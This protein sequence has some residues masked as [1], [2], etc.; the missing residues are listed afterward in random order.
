MKLNFLFL[1][2][3]FLSVM[4]FP[5]GYHKMITDKNHWNY[6]SIHSRLI[7]EKDF[8]AD[9]FGDWREEVM[10]SLNKSIYFF[11]YLK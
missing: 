6:I 1:C 10:L 11:K 7:P 5:N 4:V 2:F 9:F 8:S 3:M